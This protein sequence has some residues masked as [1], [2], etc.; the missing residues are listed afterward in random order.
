MQDR[1][2]QGLRGVLDSRLGPGE[3]RELGRG[4]MLSS[5]T[6][7]EGLGTQSVAT[8]SG[9]LCHRETSV[10]KLPRSLLC[11]IRFPSTPDRLPQAST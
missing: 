5:R 6:V 11:A 3:P 8:C 10:M 7:E 4:S 1:T 9:W 2:P